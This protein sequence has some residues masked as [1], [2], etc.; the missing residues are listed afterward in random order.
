MIVV[1]DLTNDEKKEI[2]ESLDSKSFEELKSICVQR[3]IK[4][5]YSKC[6]DEENNK[7]YTK[8]AISAIKE[9][10]NL[11]ESDDVTAQINELDIEG[12]KEYVKNRKLDLEITDDMT[13]EDARGF[14]LLAEEEKS[15]N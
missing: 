15:G 1:E 9:A 6:K 4:V 12:L 2:I 3:K 14:V 13:L 5:D 10:L 8:A 11:A 7:E